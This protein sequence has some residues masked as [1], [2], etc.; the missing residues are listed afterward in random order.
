[1]EVESWLLNFPD[2]GKEALWPASAQQT[3]MSNLFCIIMVC[4]L[5]VESKNL[6]VKKEI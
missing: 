5:E 4:S 6:F 1:V 2:K 3:H